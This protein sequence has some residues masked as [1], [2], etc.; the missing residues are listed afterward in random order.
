MLPTLATFAVNERERL[1]ARKLDR[2]LSRLVPRALAE[3]LRRIGALALS[4]AWKIRL[5]LKGDAMQPAT[6]V[7]RYGA[8]ARPESPAIPWPDHAQVENQRQCQVG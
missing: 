6:I 7:T 5:A 2:E 4:A 1:R 3:R 8:D